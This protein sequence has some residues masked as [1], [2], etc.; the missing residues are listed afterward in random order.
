MKKKNLFAVAFALIALFT[1]NAC[2]IDSDFEEL[3]IESVQSED[4]G[5]AADNT[6]GSGVGGNPPPARAN[7]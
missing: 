1:L 7:P 3:T 4:G 2:T 6:N 5:D